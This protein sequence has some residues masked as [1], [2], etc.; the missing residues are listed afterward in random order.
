VHYFKIHNPNCEAQID[1]NALIIR[2]DA[3][4][5]LK[6][7]LRGSLKPMK[8][9]MDEKKKFIILSTPEL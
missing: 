4:L 3:K 9:G 6:I 7:I 2:G 5:G 8:L 1:N